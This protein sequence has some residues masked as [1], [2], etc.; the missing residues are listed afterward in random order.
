MHLTSLAIA[1]GVMLLD[2]PLAFAQQLHVGAI[3]QAQQFLRIGK[4]EHADLSTWLGTKQGRVD[5]SRPLASTGSPQL[6][7]MPIQTGS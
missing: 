7:E 2:L 6:E 3:H 4:I 5:E 1:R